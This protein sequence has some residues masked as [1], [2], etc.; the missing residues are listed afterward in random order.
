MNRRQ[1]CQ[2]IAKECT[3]SLQV[4]KGWGTTWIYAHHPD[5]TIISKVTCQ[6]HGHFDVATHIGNEIERV[7]RGMDHKG[8]RDW[9]YRGAIKRWIK[10]ARKEVA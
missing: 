4:D 2:Q 10:Q 9:Q 3:Y 6:Y 7:A 1:I 8:N 5:P